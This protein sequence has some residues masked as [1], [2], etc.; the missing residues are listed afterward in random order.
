MNR[1]I[2]IGNGFDLAHK[3]PTSFKEFLD[4]YWNNII[5]EIAQVKAW[6]KFENEDI[7]IDKRPDGFDLGN[8]FDTLKA[9]LKNAG[10]RIG[11]KNKFLKRISEQSSINKW[12]DIENEYYTLLV[13]SFKNEKS[14][15]KISDLNNDFE[16]IKNA[17]IQYITEIENTSDLSNNRCKPQIASKIY[18]RFEFQDFTENAI[19]QKAEL[20]LKKAKD[21]FEKG[22]TDYI[23]REKLTEEEKNLIN[24]LGTDNDYALVRRLLVSQTAPNYFNLFPDNILFLN[25]NYTRSEK[26]YK[27]PETVY[28]QNLEKKVYPETISIHGTVYTQDKN[29]VIFGFGDE[30]DENY[31]AIENLNDNK[32]L[33]HIKSIKYL[34]TNNYKRLLE[35]I[36]S[37]HYQILIFGHSCGNS[38]RTLLNTLFEH[39]NCVSIKPYYYKREESKDNYSEIVMNITRNFNDKAALRDKV[40]NKQY[41][42]QLCQNA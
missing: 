11:F 18:S 28:V 35:F 36:N 42:E 20:E 26:H 30:I 6:Q 17:L 9:G 40:V 14:E 8:N 13:K 34:E 25:F 23:V 12:V 21:N 2:L 1:I 3:L 32:F 5:F 29:P 22:Q 16:R 38:D 10:S 4:N 15:I 19:N 37:D 31:K 33:E 39:N 27:N 7:F 24:K 41:C